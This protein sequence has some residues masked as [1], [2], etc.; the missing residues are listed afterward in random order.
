MNSLKNK[1]R[2]KYFTGIPSRVHREA[3]YL[4]SFACP[5]KGKFA[6]EEILQGPQ[7]SSA[8]L[9]LFESQKTI[10]TTAF[11]PSSSLPHFTDEQTRHSET[12]LNW[13]GS[14]VCTKIRHRPPEPWPTACSPP[15]RTLSMGLLP[16]SQLATREIGNSPFSF[17]WERTSQWVVTEALGPYSHFTH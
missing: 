7:S 3:F 9:T 13:Q 4:P 14:W 11:L 15:P 8:C 2:R 6:N 10:R 5:N 12:F 17:P 16:H 1:W